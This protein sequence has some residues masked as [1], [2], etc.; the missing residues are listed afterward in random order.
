M[1]IEVW[2]SQN[3]FIWNMAFAISFLY[4]CS[5]LDDLLWIR[6]PA[7]VFTSYCSDR[8]ISSPN[9]PLSLHCITYF[10]TCL[11]VSSKAEFLPAV[12][13][14]HALGATVHFIRAKAH[15]ADIST[16]APS[17][18]CATAGS[19][20]TFLSQ[21]QPL[22]AIRS[23]NTHLSVFLQ[24]EPPIT[25]QRWQ[26]YCIGWCDRQAFGESQTRLLLVLP[27]TA[28]GGYLWFFSIQVVLS[29]HTPCNTW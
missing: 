29:Y 18:G 12:L 20:Q 11:I 26:I 23:Y 16:S 10:P 15:Y 2:K 4:L 24:N 7:T 27:K 3:R 8:K 5:M 25:C 9:H 22:R 21:V 1:K 14:T 17:K 6:I 28:K 13:T 19:Q